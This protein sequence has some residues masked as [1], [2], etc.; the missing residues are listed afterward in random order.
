ML[1]IFGIF[2]VFGTVSIPEIL[3]A[4]PDMVGSSIGF[5]GYRVDTMSRAVRAAVHRRDGQIG[6]AWAC[7]PGCPTRWK[8]RHRSPR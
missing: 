4:A 7:T 3:A 8:G 1:G 5:L 6:A 2:L